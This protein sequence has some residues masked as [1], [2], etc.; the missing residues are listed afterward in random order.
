M[1]IAAFFIGFLLLAS[2][3][4]DDSLKVGTRTTLEIDPVYDAGDVIKGEI[5][6]AKFK[7]TNTGEYPLH[8]GD[9]KPSCGCTTAGKP[10]EPIAPGESGYIEAKVDTDKT[11][12]GKVTKSVTITTN[13]MP[14]THQVKIVANVISK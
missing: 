6:D 3:C 11:N 12:V 5:I 13:A 10:E 9:V 7:V 8:I 14:S 1:R 4:G 2:S